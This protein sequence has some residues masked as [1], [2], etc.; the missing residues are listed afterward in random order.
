MP[1]SALN[2]APEV[3][4]ATPQHPAFGGSALRQ[5]R[6]SHSSHSSQSSHS[7]HSSYAA[8]HPD[9][10]PPKAASPN[11]AFL[12]VIG[13]LAL[14][15][16]QTFAGLWLF[17]KGF[18]LTRHELLGANNCTR[19]ADSAWTL[20]APP[21]AFDDATLL[22]WAEMLDPQ[23]GVGECRLKPT[24]SKAIVIVVD[25]LRYDFIA[26]PPAAGSVS[27]R[28]DL[29]WKPNPHYHSVLTL[30]AQLT[31][32]HGSPVHAKRPGPAGFLAHFVADPPTTTLQRL[33]G[34]TAGTLPTFFEAGANFGSAGTGVGRVHEDTW[35]AQLRASIL[36]QRGADARAGLVFAGDDTW[37]TVLPGLFDNDT[38][39]TYDSFNV[40]DLDTVDRG[41]ESRL[42]PFLQPQHP[43]RKA[44]VHDHWRLL[45]GHTLGVDHV[46]HRFG[47]SHEK[48]ATKL[49]EMQRFLQ[50][51]TDAMDDDMLLVVLGDHGMDEHG[52]HGGDGEL[53]V[54]AGIWMYAKSG[55]GHTARGGKMDAAEYIS[56][57][58]LEALL[59]SR[60]AFSP[61]PSPPYGGHRS[62]PQ[63]DLVPTLALL[64]GVGVPYSNLGSVV[65][66]LF[67]HPDTLLRALRITATQM[68][69]YLAAYATQSPDLTAFRP[70]LDT[71]WLA[72]VRADAELAA[73]LHGRAAQADVE[74]LWRKAAQ[75]YHAFNRVSLVSARSV[76]AQ[77]DQVRIGLGLL[78]LVLGLASAWVLRSGARAGLIGRLDAD[79]ADGDAKVE[80]ASS[81]A[82]E[83]GRVVYAAVRTP[84]LVGGATGAAAAVATQLVPAGVANLTLLDGLL[85]GSAVGSQLGLLLSASSANLRRSIRSQESDSAAVPTTTRALDAAGWIV[86]LL[87]AGSFASNSLLIFEDRFVLLASAVL[88]L[89]RGAFAVGAASTQRQQVRLG[90]MAVVALLL[91]RAASMPRV[92][93]EEQGAS[94]TSTFFAG[95][96]ALNSPY[97]MVGSYAAA[98]ALPRVVA[99]FLAQSR[100]YVGV[101]PM[102]FT[103]ALRPALML[104]AGYWVLDWAV[105]LN[106]VQA[107]GEAAR[108]EWV[109]GWVAVVALGLPGV[110][111]VFWVFAPLCLEIRRE[112]AEAEGEKAKVTILGYSNSLGS[113][114]VLLVGAVFAVLFL[115]TQPAGQLA[116]AA[117]LVA[118]LAAMEL[119]DAERDRVV[120]HRQRTETPAGAVHLCAGEVASLALLG[121][122]GLF[123]SGHQ[124]TL[125]SIQWRVAF[126]T[127]PTL[128][129]P[130][131]PLLVALNS[132]GA[133]SLLPPLLVVLSVVWN[134]TPL[135]R[136]SGRKMP[137]PS[138]MLHALLT[139]ALYNALLLTA[140]AA[141]AGTLFSRH[142]MLFKVWTPRF[143][144]AATVALLAQAAAIA[145]A[146]AGWH[147][148]NKVNT[149]FG[150][151]FA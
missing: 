115:V 33:K 62:I 130:L 93:R 87:H 108:V 109:K 59:P 137:T 66:E 75:D 3:N 72:A 73:A 29:A 38:M 10:V 84:A 55:F 105:A 23:T 50:N 129:Y 61:L 2:P 80:R 8:R 132:F 127:S 21:T 124:A 49:G 71:R 22:K 131:S 150:T 92:C 64:L 83:L 117:V 52:D 26:P 9:R 100:S 112:A 14:V 79:P 89:L 45:V 42:L 113:S 143:M 48:M 133:V 111:V 16:L 25:A 20:P 110:A 126:L 140:S 138:V 51:V 18:L 95:T 32:Q 90:L 104:G 96:A 37:A 135:P 67:A 40:E 5:R 54:G 41:V 97:V 77:F 114:Y 43:D 7:S 151:E 56:T 65:P 39:W 46:G 60:I 101:A 58:E 98:Y 13:V 102:F 74:A 142:L 35:I 106:A 123:G 47:A 103:W 53:E 68:R 6:S 15:L 70:E 4:M 119:G 148:A 99:W 44:G 116:L 31:A 134:A 57:P 78:V 149:I 136:G 122:M 19:P 121:Y 125:A 86:L 147:T 144:L 12:A 30:P 146:L 69:T 27:E 91:V 28:V 118:A 128:S 107:S 76:W 63:I 85:A 145:A 34:L 120:L 94:C 36:A 11:R 82:E 81:G 139:L 141:L 24:H 17:V 88:F 1:T